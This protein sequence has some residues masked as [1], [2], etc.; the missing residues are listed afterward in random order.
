[1]TD[2]EK[3]VQVPQQQ[4]QAEG[5]REDADESQGMHDVP[6]APLQVDQAEGEPE[7]IDQ[8]V[9]AVEQAERKKR[10]R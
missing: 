2:R 8:D 1:M 10:D 9:K 3:D 6:P 4:D 5:A 7:D